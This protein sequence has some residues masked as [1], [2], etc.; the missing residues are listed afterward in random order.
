[1]AVSRLCAAFRQ[2]TIKGESN[3]IARY[4]SSHMLKGCNNALNF[5]NFSKNALIVSPSNVHIKFIPKTL[6]IDFRN[7]GST[8]KKNIYE[9]PLSRYMPSMEEPLI[10]QPI[11]QDLPLTNT[12]FELPATENILEKLAVRLMIIRKK[13]M[14]KHKRRK[15]RKR[16][17]FVWAK[18]RA[19]RN[20]TKEK[21]F[22]AELIAQI[23]EAHMFN[24][25]K[26]VEERLAILDKEILPKTFRGEILPEDMIRKFIQEKVEK[27]MRKHNRPRLT[28]D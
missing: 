17:K 8:T 21:V 12:S 15:L 27:K 14:K 2:I 10:K 24:A 20:I 22:Q 5:S 23:K 26:Y 19:N 25:K 16:M 18:I 13:K 6:D 28:L 9:I 7:P 3:I 4:Y 1:M 11:K